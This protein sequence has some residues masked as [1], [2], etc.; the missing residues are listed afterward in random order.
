[1]LEEI[2]NSKKS[3]KGFDMVRIPPEYG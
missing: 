2:N 3:A 1:M